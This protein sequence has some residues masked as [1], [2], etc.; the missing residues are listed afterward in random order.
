MVR[1]DE[2]VVENT[3]IAQWVSDIPVSGMSFSFGHFDITE[4]NATAAPV[5]TVYENK[6]ELGFSPGNLRKTI[7][8]LKGS[9]RM[10]ED[11][12]GPYPFGS[13][14]AT[15]TVAYNGQAFPGLVLLSFQAF[16]Q[17]HTGE[18]ELFRAHEVAHQWWGAAVPW[19]SYRDQWISEGFSHY[20]AALYILTSLG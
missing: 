12:F 18:A 9:I 1:V 11:Y 2:R 20:A 5:I 4:T 3:R 16:G 17:L 7:E 8:D 14:I 10:Y 15:E 13:L 6:R 19:E